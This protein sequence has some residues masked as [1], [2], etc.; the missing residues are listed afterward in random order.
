M[1]LQRL[2]L[3][4]LFIFVA[5]RGMSAEVGESRTA[6]LQ[7]KGE[8]VS[9]VEGGGRAILTFHD[10]SVITLVDDQVVKVSQKTELPTVTQNRVSAPAQGDDRRHLFSA[11]GVGVVAALVLFRVF[12]SDLDNF[13]ECL[14]FYFQPDWLSAFRGEWVEDKWST[15]KLFVWVCLSAAAGILFYGY[16]GGSVDD[17]QHFLPR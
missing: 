12:F 7:E 17:L 4:F 13:F 10:Q 1:P 5:L 3:L 16:T 11:I 6:L 15:M 8:P 2:L 9:I 14:R